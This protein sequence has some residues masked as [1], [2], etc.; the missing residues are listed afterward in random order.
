MNGGRSMNQRNEEALKMD[1]RSNEYMAAYWSEK[2][3]N[4]SGRYSS[5]TRPAKSTYLQNI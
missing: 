3:R 4:T 1:W 2:K 5:K